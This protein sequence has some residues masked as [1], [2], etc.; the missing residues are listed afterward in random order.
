MTPV[1]LFTVIVTDCEADPPG[2]LQFSVKIVAAVIA[3]VVVPLLLVGFDPL[4]PPLP[5]QAVALVVLQVKVVV[6]PDVT[7]AGV[8]L[9]EIVGGI[10]DTVT[11]DIAEL[12]PPAPL[13]P[14]VKVEVALSAE[15]TSVPLVVFEPDHAPEA[16]QDVALVLLHVRVVELPAITA[17]GFAVSVTVGCVAEIVTA[18]VADDDPPAPLHP[19]VKDE[20]ALNAEM[21]SVP[22]VVFEPDHAPEAVQDV[23]LVLLH[24]SVVELPAITAVGFAVSV[25]VGSVAEIVTVVVVEDVPPGPVQSSVNDAS[26][27]RGPIDSD[28]LVTLAPLQAPDAMH[29]VASVLLQLRVVLPPAARFELPAV[30]DTV[31][32]L[33]TAFVVFVGC[34]PFVQA[35]SAT[36]MITGNA[37]LL[38]NIMRNGSSRMRTSSAS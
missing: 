7:T 11:V 12:E 18:V 33:V 4:Q 25:T 38:L 2:P 24:V 1:A 27:L 30:S 34:T 13:H 32:T 17:V 36:A 15:V 3:P 10:D 19:S 22:L 35:V 20:V 31:G 26:A 23:A 14:S 29:E 9:N 6:P 21:I 28:P 37:D 8:A 16:V 5:V